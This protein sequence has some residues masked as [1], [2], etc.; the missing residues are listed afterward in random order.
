LTG[1]SRLDWF[2]AGRG[3][4]RGRR[5]GPRPLLKTPPLH[6]PPTPFAA[7]GDL[8]QSLQEA[9]G[10]FTSPQIVDDYAYYADTAFRLFGPNVGAC[11][12]LE[13]VREQGRLAART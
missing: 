6:N 2:A 9:Y 4:G 10:G 11:G 3:G 13:E 8:P 7:A 12:G 5:S 1:S